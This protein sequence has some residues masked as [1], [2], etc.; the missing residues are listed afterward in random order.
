[1]AKKWLTR[2]TPMPETSPLR[3]GILGCGSASIPVCEAL[4]ASPFTQL[5]AVYDGNPS[6]ADDIH[7]RFQVSKS[8]T[9]EELLADPTLDAIYVAVPHYL[10]APLTQQV[11]EAGKHALVEKPMAISLEEADKLIELSHEQQVA[12]GV[13]YEMRY[14]PAH[15]SARRFRYRPSSISP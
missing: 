14:A 15:A 5:A 9:L 2:V 3:F 12:L 11:L 7:Q 4:A 6:L 1:M 8:N 13:F 10:L